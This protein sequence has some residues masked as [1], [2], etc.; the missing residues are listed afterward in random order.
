MPG[1][2][3]ITAHSLS[4][5]ILQ[6]VDEITTRRRRRQRLSVLTIE[7]NR[8]FDDLTQLFKH[9]P[10]VVAV[11]TTVDQARRTA[12]ITLILVRPLNDLEVASTIFHDAGSGPGDGFLLI[13]LRIV[14]E[15]TRDCHRLC[16]A[17]AQSCDGYLC[18]L[19]RRTPL[20]PSLLSVLCSS[21]A[22]INPPSPAAAGPFRRASLQS[23]P[24]RHRPYHP[25]GR[26]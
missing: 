15:L 6:L 16:D 4:R 9:L 17:D 25:T 13:L 14:A 24:T 19:D 3:L 23:V 21:W 2:P 5:D 12:D 8:L 18:H 10:L 22:S 26:R 1:R 11:T 7:F 20:I